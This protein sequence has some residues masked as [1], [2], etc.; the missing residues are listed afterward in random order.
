VL[1][2]SISDTDT[3][4]QTFTPFTGA[5]FINDCLLQP[6][7]HVNHPL[8]QFADITDS[9]LSTAALFFFR[10]YNH[11]IQTWAIKAAWYPARWILSSRMQ[12]ASEI[13]SNCNFKVR[14]F[15][16]IIYVYKISSEIWQWKN[17]V[18]RPTFTEVMIKSQMY[19][20]FDSQCRWLYCVKCP[21]YSI[22]LEALGC[23]SGHKQFTFCIRRGLVSRD[24]IVDGDWLPTTEWC[25]CYL[26][27]CQPA[28]NLRFLVRILWID[29]N[30]R[31]RN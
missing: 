18:N 5:S 4:L 12:Y 25:Q 23:L 26:P 1:K 16:P 10:F 14:I 7:L 6:T 28:E 8:L 19:C 2:T 11:R 24:S 29:S 17:F 15:R 13:G 22:R 30:G 20:F 27:S 3:S 9:L 21:Q 31:N